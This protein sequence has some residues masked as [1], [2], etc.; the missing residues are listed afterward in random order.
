[1]SC[2]VESKILTCE[3]NI[4]TLGE[5]IYFIFYGIM[6]KLFKAMQSEQHMGGRVAFCLHSYAKNKFPCLEGGILEFL[7]LI[8]DESYIRR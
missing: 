8:K 5:F 7:A 3:Y 6:F 2:E 1:M 4:Y